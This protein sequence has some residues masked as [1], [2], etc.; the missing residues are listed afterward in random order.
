[1]DRTAIVILAAGQARRMGR[2]KQL[3][4]WKDTTLLGHAV[5]GARSVASAAVFVVT[6]AYRPQ[7]EAHVHAL[8]VPAIHNPRY[9]EGL[10]TSIAAAA[11]YLLQSPERYREVLLLLADQPAVTADHLRSLIEHCRAGRCVAATAYPQGA[12]VPAAFPRSTFAALQN[13]G[14]DAGARELLNGDVYS[15]VL[16]A[17]QAP[18]FDIDTPEDYRA[19]EGNQE[20]N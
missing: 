5:A 4:A 2:P 12:G 20:R 11:A 14:G 15:V 7:V 6:G 19:H 18:L 8:G 3:L 1:M 9:A 10:G 17:P 16:V 13:L